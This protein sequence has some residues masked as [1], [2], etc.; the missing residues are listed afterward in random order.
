MDL[1]IIGAFLA[2]IGALGLGTLLGDH[3]TRTEARRASRADALNALE[4]HRNAITGSAAQYTSASL[5][6]ERALFIAM[7]PRWAHSDYFDL[8]NEN[9]KW[10]HNG[11]SSSELDDRT[12]DSAVM[13]RDAIYKGRL[14]RTLLRARRWRVRRKVRTSQDALTKLVGQSVGWRT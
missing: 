6:L 4:H 12:R 8:A 1:E 13:V 9:A 11:S 14:S 10:T 2:G 7:V 3:L 5:D